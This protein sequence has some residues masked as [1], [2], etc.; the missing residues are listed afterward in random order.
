MWINN[1]QYGFLP[2]KNTMDAIVQIIEDWNHALDQKK[3]VYAIFFDYAKAF[4]LVDHVILMRKLERYLPKWLTSWIAVWLS[5]RKQRV[6]C[7][8]DQAS[9]PWK[10]VVAGVIQGSVLGPILF[11]LFIYDLNEYMPPGI[12]LQKYADDILA[13]IISD[14]PITVLA[15]EIADGVARWCSDNKMRL[16]TGK[17]KTMVIEKATKPGS[18]A[19]THFTV[20]IDNKPLEEVDEYK[21]LGI[22]INNKLNW[23]QQ[24]LRV[25]KITRPVIYLIRTVKKM[26]LTKE[27]LV[28]VYRSYALAHFTYSAPVLTSTSEKDKH[29]MNMFQKVILRKIGITPFEAKL[30]YNISPITELID[31]VC[32][33]TLAKILAD[34]LHS[35]TTK[36]SRCNRNESKF[37]FKPAKAKTVRYQKSFVQKFMRTMRDGVDNKY[38]DNRSLSNYNTDTTKLTKR[39]APVNYTD[40]ESIAKV[41]QRYSCPTCGMSFVNL[42]NH[43]TRMHPHAS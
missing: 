38:S 22:L 26:G 1:K 14:Q 25:Q 5:E 24:W 27:A 41:K 35:L 12:E 19:P 30:K 4:D 7:P 15:Q 36:L 33:K 8:Q 6:L 21:Y 23:Q 3:H 11:L 34:P 40:L 42:K 39:S 9:V 16:N 37:Q 43:V 29:E 17:C 13:Y 28:H 2:G 18:P 20:N 10:N 31:A 32:L